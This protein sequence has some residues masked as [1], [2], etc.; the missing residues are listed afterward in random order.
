MSNKD[1]A[2]IFDGRDGFYKSSTLVSTW[3]NNVK[4]GP[5]GTWKKDSLG[6]S[7]YTYLYDSHDNEIAI[8]DNETGEWEK[9]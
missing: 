3:A 8:R 9:K 7:R 6:D 1:N 2:E 4:R 5:D